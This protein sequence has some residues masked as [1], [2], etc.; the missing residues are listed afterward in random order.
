MLRKQIFCIFSLRGNISSVLSTPWDK[1]SISLEK[2]KSNKNFKERL[3]SSI[4]NSHDP[5]DSQAMTR[6][7]I[8]PLIVMAIH[9]F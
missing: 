7:L 1:V 9:L 3:G 8:A 2:K 5:Q 4:V 6:I